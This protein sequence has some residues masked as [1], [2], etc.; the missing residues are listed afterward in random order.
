MKMLKY[1]MVAD[2]LQQKI[3][4]GLYKPNDQLPLVPELCEQYDVSKITIK[5]AMDQLMMKGYIVK[6]RGAGTF[7]K[8]I[9]V[10]KSLR[11][12]H[13]QSNQLSGMYAEFKDIGVE[14]KTIVNDFEIVTPSDHVAQKLKISTDDFVY[15]ICRTRLAD[16]VPQVIEYTYMPIDVVPGLKNEDVATSIYGYIQDTLKLKVDSAHRTVRAVLPTDKEQEMLA[17]EPGVP[18]LQV[19]QVAFLED[20][21]LF[22]YSVSQH[23]GN[24]YEFYSISVQG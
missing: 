12:F 22:E 14:I 16:G 4:N 13:E 10:G 6:R 24:L 5:K 18:L 3:E 15:W 2:D 9:N 7:V 23:P 20:G 8:N 11:A 21:R 19:E 1:E 17:M